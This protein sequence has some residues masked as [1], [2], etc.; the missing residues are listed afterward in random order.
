MK[1]LLFTLLGC[2]FLLTTGSLYAQDVA[3]TMLRVRLPKKD[4]L[5]A[6]REQVST[7]FKS[8]FEQATSLAKKMSLATTLSDAADNSSSI[9][10][11]YAMREHSFTLAAEAGYWREALQ[12]CDRLCAEFNVPHATAQSDVVLT[13]CESLPAARTR[14]LDDETLAALI[15]DSLEGLL[16]EDNYQAALTT[17]PYLN[18]R[19]GF[20]AMARDYQNL[21]SRLQQA[22]NSE[23]A[24]ALATLKRNPLDAA[25]HQALA[26]FYFKHKED[27]ETALPHYA[28]GTQSTMKALALRELAHPSTL[29]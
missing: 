15:I 12:E 1:H 26:D 18:S 29:R 22:Y 3:P 9:A 6:A 21:T 5:D 10:E 27:W 8:E 17:W 19:P 4:A 11:R 2:L 16:L 14:G 24:P 20:G 7:R 23:A 13:L 28:L 25:A